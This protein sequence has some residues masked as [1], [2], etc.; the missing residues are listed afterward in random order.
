MYGTLPVVSV[1]ISVSLIIQ[2]SR[3]PLRVITDQI[4]YQHDHTVPGDW[5]NTGS[6]V[7]HNG[8]SF[9]YQLIRDGEGLS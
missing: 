3:Y 6:V 5:F 8:Q 4:F 9:C 1:S 7:L 2:I